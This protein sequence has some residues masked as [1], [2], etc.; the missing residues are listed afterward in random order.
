L[1]GSHL[2]PEKVIE[3]AQH[4][5][6]RTGMRATSRLCKVGLNTVLRLAVRAGQHAEAFHDELVHHVEVNQVQADEAWAFVG[7]K[8]QALRPQRS[9]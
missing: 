8:G 6:E 4:L 9:R 7:K 5:V 2:P 3:I 1:F